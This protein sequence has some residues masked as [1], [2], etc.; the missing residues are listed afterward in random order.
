MLQKTPQRRN[1]V[2]QT[3]ALCRATMRTS[4]PTARL[5]LPLNIVLSTQNSCPL[6]QIC[7]HHCVKVGT[8][9][10]W[11]WNHQH[12]TKSKFRYTSASG[13]WHKISLNDELPQSQSQL[14]A[15]KLSAGPLTRE[16]ENCCCRRSI[17]LAGR[18]ISLLDSQMDVGM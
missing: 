18:G 1:L 8:H 3:L 11:M 7:G 16:K 6:G 9:L 14:T 12:N 15:Q 17:P 5:W 4:L 13:E 10:D 2:G